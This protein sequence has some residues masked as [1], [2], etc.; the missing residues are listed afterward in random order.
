[1]GMHAALVTAVLF[2]AAISQ[3]LGEP[4]PLWRHIGCYRDADM[5]EG[6]RVIPPLEH[7]DEVL[8][9]QYMGR[10]G[11]I[12]KCAIA[13]WNKGYPGFALQDGGWC[14]GSENILDMY[15]IW[16]SAAKLQ[17]PYNCKDG[18]GGMWSN[19]VYEIIGYEQPAEAG[20]GGELR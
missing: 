15:D 8:D 12:K 7:M 9:G 14:G 19:D 4:G 3:T 10:K 18:K 6:K 1:M 17:P 2:F 20:E 13:A 5:G 11:A 16:G